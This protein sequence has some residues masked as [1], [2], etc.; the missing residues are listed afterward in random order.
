MSE[1]LPGSGSGTTSSGTGRRLSYR[2]A[3][4][5]RDAA[6]AAKR[7]ILDLIATTSRPEVLSEPGGFGGLFRVPA[8]YERPV[9]VASADGVG[10]KLK[11]AQRAGRHDTV[12]RDLVNH[13]VNDILAEGA[14][15]LFFLDYIGMG[16]LE[17]GVVDAVVAG[18]ATGCREN[19]CA[20]LGGETAEMPDFYAPG[21]YDLAGFVVGAV[22]DAAR[23]GAARVVPGDALIGLASNGFHTNGYSLLRKLLFERLGLDLDDMFPDLTASVGDV[24]LRV[25]R[26]YLEA[27]APLVDEGIVRALAHITGGGL[28]E[29]LARALPPGVEARVDTAAWTVPDEFLSV[30]RHGGIDA[31]EMFRTFNMGIGLVLIVGE[32]VAADVVERLS[33]GGETAWRIGSVAGGDRGVVLE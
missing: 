19:G 4:V 11:V 17:P 16:R 25:H 32:D 21:E 7:G 29:N 27:V 3:G 26:S 23:L 14:R 24:L 15:P 28:P 9:L 20:L 33:R 30:E 13:C 6:S 22:E 2:D 8:G 5:D 18:V 12:G 31:A 10:T 1:G